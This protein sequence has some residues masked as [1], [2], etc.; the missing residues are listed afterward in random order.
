MSYPTPGNAP[1]S[2][3]G[4]A[5]GGASAYD[6]TGFASGTWTGMY[7]GYGGGYGAAPG[8]GYVPHLQP[9]GRYLPYS[10]SPYNPYLSG[11]LYTYPDF[12]QSQIYPYSPY[13]LDANPPAGEYDVPVVQEESSQEE[14]PRDPQPPEEHEGGKERPEER[15]PHVEHVDWSAR[16][17]Q[18]IVLRGPRRK[19]VALTFDDGP[20]E[21]FTPK[22]LD[23]LAKVNVK[24][25]FFIFGRRGERFP[26]VLRRIVREGHIV[27][28][29]TYTHP[30][31]TKLKPE[32]VRFQLERTDEVIRRVTG[33][34]PALFRPP[35]GAINDTVIREVIRLK[36]KIIFW[37]VDSLDWMQLN[38]KQVTAN[39]LAHVRPGS[40]IL[41]HAAGGVGENLQGTVDAIPVVVN[42][43]RSRGYRF[44]TIPQLINIPA[45]V[46]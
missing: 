31:L 36:K 18:H 44:R 32:Q 39:I 19:E 24:A 34:T 27:G 12:Y 26:E 29:H 30:N 5:G 40:I 45:Y 21:E 35:Y 20:D 9:P 4:S 14:Q 1:G 42:E 16:Y 23:Q 22:V 3:S 25:T 10:Y 6:S 41:Q 46:R 11:G 8:A 7:P 43:L 28:N 15:P 17:P 13:R 2:I 38:A 33:K 37:N